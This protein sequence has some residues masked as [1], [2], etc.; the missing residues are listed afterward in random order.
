MPRYSTGQTAT[1]PLAGEDV[2]ILMDGPPWSG[3]PARRAGPRCRSA[4]ST[5]LN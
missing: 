5:S 2:L 3:R 4:R 1:E